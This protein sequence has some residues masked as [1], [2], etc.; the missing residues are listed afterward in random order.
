MTDINIQELRSAAENYRATLKAHRQNPTSVEAMEAWDRAN[1]EFDALINNDEINIISTL[2][3][4]LERLQRANAAQ[5][6]HIN[7]QQDRIEELES[8]NSGAGKRIRELSAQKDEWERKATSNFEECARM[9]KRIDELEAQVSA[10]PVSFFAYSDEIGFE[11][12][13]TE[14]EAKTAAQNEI[15]WNRD[16]DPEDGWPEGV[17]SIRWGY[18]MQRAKEVDIRVVRRGRKTREC[19]YELAP[20]LNNAAGISK[21]E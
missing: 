6:D 20:P 17:D 4:E 1:S 19:D 7:Q 9:S 21:G 5:D 13:D 11:I 12:Y 10:D 15:D 18:V 14:Q 2:F 16:V 3:D 8:A